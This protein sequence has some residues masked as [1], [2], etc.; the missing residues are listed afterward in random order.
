MRIDSH[1]DFSIGTPEND[2]VHVFMSKTSLQDIENR[3]KRSSKLYEIFP[4]NTIPC[5]SGQREVG[6]SRLME[7]IIKAEAAK[8]TNISPMVWIPR[9]KEAKVARMP[10]SNLGWN[11]E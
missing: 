6:F 9:N 5:R 7:P 1:R 10:P 8:E 3:W 4:G 2:E 11:A